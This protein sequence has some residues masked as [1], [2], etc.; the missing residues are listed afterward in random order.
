MNLPCDYSRCVGMTN[1][2]TKTPGEP[3]RIERQCNDCRRREP[4]HPERQV[5]L[6]APESAYDDPC[7]HYIGPSNEGK[8]G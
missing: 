6:K 7:P 1:W 3:E 2:R 4:G 5:Y 8:K